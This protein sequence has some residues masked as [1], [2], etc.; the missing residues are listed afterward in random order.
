MTKV[1]IA[2]PANIFLCDL[3]VGKLNKDEQQICLEISNTE[4]QISF[5]IY[6]VIASLSH[7]IFCSNIV[8]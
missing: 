1:A 7:I 4:A 6:F 3:L 5:F 2:A 8:N